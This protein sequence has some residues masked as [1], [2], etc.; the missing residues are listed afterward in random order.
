MS[1]VNCLY[2]KGEYDELVF[3]GETIIFS[4][5]KKSLLPNDGSENL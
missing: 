4:Y 1:V 2:I 3:N 5:S